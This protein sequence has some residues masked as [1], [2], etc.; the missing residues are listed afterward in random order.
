MTDFN[1][2]LKKALKKAKSSTEEQKKLRERIKKTKIA[3]QQV[4][5]KTQKML[6]D[7]TTGFLKH[8]YCKN[9]KTTLLSI[10]RGCEK[11]AALPTL[12]HDPDISN[13]LMSLVCKNL[14]H[15]VLTI[16]ETF[17]LPPDQVAEH[18]KGGVIDWL[19]KIYEE[20]NM[21]KLQQNILS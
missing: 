19:N 17:E 21:P 8:R 7:V 15:T 2:K 9:Q 3:P 11:W 20:N 4:K 13:Y 6:D 16:A 5:L 12:I 10:M 1:K 14:D 18:V